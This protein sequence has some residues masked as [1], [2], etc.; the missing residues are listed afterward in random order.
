[1][2][3]RRNEV[4]FETERTLLEQKEE[5]DILKREIDYINNSKADIERAYK[6]IREEKNLIDREIMTLRSQVG[7]VNNSILTNKQ[8]TFHSTINP[9]DYLK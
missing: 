4:I 5:N 9:G 8:A 6:A 2:K 7:S 3:N 1:M